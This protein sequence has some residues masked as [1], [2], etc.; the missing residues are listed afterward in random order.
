MS[1]TQA[2]ART[3]MLA[4]RAAIWGAIALLVL[5]AAATTPST[6]S[7]ATTAANYR[8]D[9][10]R[11]ANGTPVG[12]CRGWGGD[13][14]DAGNFYT[15]C[16]VLRDLDGNG[17]GD[18][19]APALYE[20]DPTGVVQRIGWMP[21]EY[22]FD[23]RYPIRDVGVS[24]DGTVA[25]VSTGPNFDKL[26]QRPDLHPRTGAPLANGAT[27]GSILRLVRKADGSW[28][29]DG[30]KAGPFMIA[31]NYW[32]IR[33][34]DVDGAGRIYVSVN[35]FVYQLDPAT[36]AVVSSFGGAITRYPGGPWVEGI[37]KPEGL[38]IT[39]DGSTAY[40]VDQQHQIVQR[41]KRVG[42]TDWTR[43]RSFLLG[44]PSEVGDYC[45]VHTHFQSPYD[46]QLDAAGDVYVMDTTCQ[47]IQRFTN[48][49]AFVQT[50]WTN[51]GGDDMNHG[52][53]V[54]WQG[55][56]LLPIEE[57]VLV[58]LD[59]PAK[60]KAAPAPAP[61]CTDRTAPSVTGVEAP[62]RTS[63][64]RVT[65]TAAV[66]DDCGA[67]HVRVLGQRIGRGA[68]IPGTTLTVPLSGWNGRKSLLVQVR[69]AGGRVAARRVHVVLALPQPTLQVRA[70]V[71]LPGAGCSAVPPQRRMRGYVVV[72]R[73]ARIVGRV[74]TLRRHAQGA[75]AEL[76]LPT[77]QARALYANAVGPVRIWVVT[78]RLTRST[79]DL[80]RGRPAIVVGTL[81]LDRSA[82]VL[83]ALPVDHVGGR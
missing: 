29:H 59:P 40:V 17:T 10:A 12:T 77:G 38:T 53:A 48:A 1:S 65:I 46:V 62:A 54:N 58:R 26:G 63:T 66:E 39:P 47:R 37:D 11:Y 67:T 4:A 25:Y 72:D 83:H 20:L 2:S 45:R 16:P 35:Q 28:V 18:V 76:L 32:A 64:R 71:A 74:L 23:D 7:A 52:L 61:G 41:W 3:G 22:A 14:D 43:D 44:T 69:D 15:A 30:F 31:G 60:P 8:L 33:S 19:Q 81:V 82:G 27:A 13:A 24:P 56:I 70:R 36:G 49:G 79:G 78:D 68:W 6:A 42:A 57:D 34:V 50:V 80:R 9:A 75:S 21:A 5:L 73:C 55:S 51:T